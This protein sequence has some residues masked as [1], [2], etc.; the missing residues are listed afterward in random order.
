MA[1][2]RTR[3]MLKQAGELLF[4]PQYRSELARQ[5]GVHL[6]TV[7][8]WDAGETTIPASAL[9]RLAQLLKERRGRIDALLHRIEAGS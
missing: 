1:N 3:S 6:R 7:M 2:Q 5:L 8:R 4:G 9:A